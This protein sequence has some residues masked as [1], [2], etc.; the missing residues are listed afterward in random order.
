MDEQSF[1]LLNK[2]FNKRNKI[3]NLIYALYPKEKSL[4]LIKKYLIGNYFIF[5]FI[6]YY[7][8]YLSFEKCFEGIHECGRK[9]NWIKKKITQAIISSII[10]SILIEIMILRLISF[11]NLF[12]IILVYSILYKYSNGMDFYD[13]GF[14][15]FVG[16]IIIIITCIITILPFNFLL[17]LIKKNNK[18]LIIIYIIFLILLLIFFFYYINSFLICKD[19]DIGLN[20]TY[21]ENNINKYGCQIRIPKYCP[22]IIGK[23]FL[24]A[25]KRYGIKCKG[26]LNSK[27]NIL[28]F[29]KSPYITNN[30]NIFGFPLTNKDQICLLRTNKNKNRNV[31]YFTKENLIDMDNENI[32]K[33][34][35]NN[36]PEIIVDFSKNIYGKM[37]IKLNFNKSLSEQRKKMENNSNAYSNNIILLYFD[38]ISRNTGLRQ[39]KKTLKFIEDFMSYKGKYN[40]KTK[41]TYHSFQFFKYHSFKYYTRGNYPKLFYWADISKKKMIRITKFLKQNGYITA[42]SNDMCNRDSCWLPQDLTFDEICDH[43]L[44]ICDPNMKSAN[45]MIKKCLYNKINAD[46][47]YEYGYQFWTKYKNNRK[48]LFIVNNDGHEG[49]LELLKYDDDIVFNFLNKIYNQNL[50]KNST[51]LLLSDH[52]CPMPSI[53]YF[54]DFF[55]IEENLPMCYILMNDKINTSYNNQYKYLYQ[56]QQKLITAYDI[57]NTIIYLIYGNEYYKRNIP[58][59][60]YGKHLFSKINSKRTPNDYHNMVTDTCVN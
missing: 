48:F 29:S 37:T 6:S 22:Y 42:F 1:Y 36:T 32:L 10:L 30:T 57:Y 11:Y 34:L 2:K 47:Q 27:K 46:Y 19:W 56:N 17:Y 40:R 33:A 45:S 7:L 5:F 9:I 14:F 60:K 54:N 26:D 8:Y 44:I 21:I 55:Q 38:S 28:M 49:T 58:K 31:L 53:Y 25:T 51:V 41:D 39:L 16:S 12:H 13:H 50:L 18:K 59:S 3:I 52:G 23:Y 15:N 43:E 35:G 20:N 24:D 4:Y